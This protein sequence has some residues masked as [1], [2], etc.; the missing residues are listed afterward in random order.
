MLKPLGDRVVVEPQKQEQVTASGIVLPEQAKEKPVQGKIIAVGRGRIENG[1]T[2]PLDVKVGDT[3]YYNKY[4]G[5][6]VKIDGKEYLI[7]RESDILAV[8]ES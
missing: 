4:A 8:L 6:E 5:T 7:M 3:V 1:K 2:I